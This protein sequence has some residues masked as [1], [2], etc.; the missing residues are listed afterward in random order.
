MSNGGANIRTCEEFPT[1]CAGSTPCRSS[2][3]P[4]GKKPRPLY[5]GEGQTRYEAMRRAIRKAISQASTERDFARV[6]RQQG[7]LWRREEGRKYATLRSLDGGRAV[8][9]YRL[10]AEYDWPTLERGAWPR[11]L[12]GTAPT[13]M[14]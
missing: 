7:Y 4:G 14:I 12:P 3:S 2:G 13:S 8:R 9:I 5:E 10:G 11:T 6:L 1:S